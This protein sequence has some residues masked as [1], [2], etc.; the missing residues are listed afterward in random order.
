M[1]DKTISQTMQLPAPS[2]GALKSSQA[3]QNLI[4]AKIQQQ[5]PITFAEYMELVLYCPE[6]GY[7]SGEMQKFGARGDFVTAPEI[8]P[9]FAAC[10]ARQCEE[11]LAHL[12]GGDILEIGAGTGQM[13]VDILLALKANKAT[14][15]NPG[16]AL[17]NHYFI[18][19][20]SPYLKK[21]QQAKIQ[22]I[23]PEF[24]PKMHWLEEKDLESPDAFPFSEF[25]G[26]I[27]ANEVLDAMPVHYFQMKDNILY[28]L[29]VDTHEEKLF[30]KNCAVSLNTMPELLQN[31]VAQIKPYEA[32]Y[33]FEVNLHLKKWIEN[34][35]RFLHSG[36]MLFIDYGFPRQEYYHHDRHMGTLMCHYQHLAHHDPCLYP[37]LQDLTCHV[38]FTALAEAASDANMEVLGYTDQA[39]FLIAAG[40]LEFA[41]KYYEDEINDNTKNRIQMN[42]AI[43]L[44]TNPAEM[45]ELFKVM[46]LGKNFDRPLWGFTLNDKRHRL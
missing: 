11:V 32:Y 45:G 19:E 44:L 23:C 34:L 20:K 15:N 30:L 9:L 4:A 39:N 28:E 12:N 3:L 8:S 10:L 26:V 29:R 46:A 7:Y 14:T 2:D 24:L 25:K 17:L 40:L 1:P 21:I 6:L 22:Q 36:I 38:D 33:T 18:L 27:L 42:H 16:H 13:A 41:Q 31:I 5:G 43:H 37:G 35:S